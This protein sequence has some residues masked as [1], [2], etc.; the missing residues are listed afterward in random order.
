MA[1]FSVNH[2]LSQPKEYAEFYDVL[3]A[4]THMHVMD[5]CWLIESD[6][7]ARSIRDQLMPHI[8]SSD[9]LF[10]TRVSQ[11]WAGAG[12]QCGQWLNEDGRQ[13]N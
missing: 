3:E 10:V 11:D 5:S 13:Y 4:H 12:T 9:A 8:H 7:D 1:I 6:G 2:D